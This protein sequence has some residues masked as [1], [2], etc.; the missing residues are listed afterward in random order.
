MSGVSTAAAVASGVGAAAQLGGSILSAGAQTDAAN[1]A[2]ATQLAM[3][4][5]MQQNLQPYMDTGGAA[6]KLLNDQLPSLTAPITMDQATLEKTPGYQFNKT[7]GLESVQNGFAARGLGSSGAA[8]KGAAEFATGLADNTYQNQ[9]N[10]AVTNQT[11]TFNRLMGVT[12][13]GE[14]A[15]AG[16]GQAGISTGNS[17]ASNTIGAGNATAA[18]INSGASGLGTGAQ[19]YVVA[20]ALFNNPNKN[21]NPVSGGGA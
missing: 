19:N 17:I 14:N 8:M 16:V 7:Q 3:F 15:A 13:L 6:N 21:T 12:N 5:K 4:N 1:S 20:N 2:S 18:A 10:N 11:N 9:F